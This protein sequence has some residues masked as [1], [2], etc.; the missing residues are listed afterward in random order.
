MDES[1]SQLTE[2]SELQ[3]PASNWPEIVRTRVAAGALAVLMIVIGLLFPFPVGG[4]IWD[5]IFNLGHAPAFCAL[6]LLMV[7]LLDPSAVGL[8]NRFGTLFRMT[9]PRTAALAFI[10]SWAGLLGELLQR[11]S[12]RHASWG[13][14]AANTVG[15]LAAWL[16]LVGRALR[17]QLGGLFAGFS[18]VLLLAVSA[19]PI[20]DIVD[21]VQQRQAFPVLSSMERSR[22]LSIWVAQNATISRSTEWAADGAAS[23]KVRLQPGEFSGVELGWPV[24]DWTGYTNFRFDVRNDGVTDLDLDVKIQDRN[25]ADSGFDPGDRFE[26]VVHIAA[27]ESKVV[28]ILLSEIESAPQTRRL[29]LDEIVAIEFFCSD[30]RA[31]A[32][33][34][35]DNLRLESEVADSAAY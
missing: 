16:W 21:S 31:G 10:L 19:G 34:F 18:I 17:G 35:L 3:R 24:T 33:L 6:L 2:P 27:G 30:L 23:L 7:A 29:L 1:S 15:L 32:V 14:A 4:R 5:A 25:H 26:R 12:G 11:Y 22:E 13:D 20:Q 28:R 9:L 8:P